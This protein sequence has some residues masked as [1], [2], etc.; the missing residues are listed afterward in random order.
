MHIAVPCTLAHAAAWHQGI[1]Y[2]HKDLYYVVS[3]V[4]TYRDQRCS[5]Y[6]GADTGQAGSREEVR[7]KSDWNY[8]VEHL[9]KHPQSHQ[10]PA[11]QRSD[12]SLSIVSAVVRATLV[13]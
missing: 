3:N 7:L 5:N 8:T 11:I 13:L 12:H 6:T 9:K 1:T 10:K 4:Q 2:E